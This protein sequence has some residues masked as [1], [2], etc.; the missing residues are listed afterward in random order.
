MSYKVVIEHTIKPGKYQEVLEWIRTKKEQRSHS[1]VRRFIALT[2]DVHRF[3]A[4][5]E[6]ETPPNNTPWVETDWGH[7]HLFS[8]VEFKILKSIDV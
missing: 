4:E 5:I 1:E 8:K 3:F 6:M 2:G 7:E